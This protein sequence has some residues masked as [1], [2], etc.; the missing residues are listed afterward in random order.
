MPS[1]WTQWFRRGRHSAHTSRVSVV[2]IISRLYID[3]YGRHAAFA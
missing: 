3:T 2:E 1:R